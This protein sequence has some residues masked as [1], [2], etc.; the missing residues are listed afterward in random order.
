VIAPTTQTISRFGM[1]Y[2]VALP[3]IGAVWGQADVD[4]VVHI[5]VQAVNL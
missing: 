2:Y 5:F 4:R 1:E 3:G